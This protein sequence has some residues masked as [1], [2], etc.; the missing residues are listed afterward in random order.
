MFNAI[1]GNEPRDLLSALAD[2]RGKRGTAMVAEVVHHASAAMACLASVMGISDGIS[3][4]S[5]QTTK[6][7]SM[8]DINRRVAGGVWAISLSVAQFLAIIGSLL[9]RTLRVYAGCCLHVPACMASKA[10]PQLLAKWTV[11]L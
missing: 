6:H 8:A 7:G 2:A 11:P 4:T 5:E 9:V 10:E 3:C 1:E